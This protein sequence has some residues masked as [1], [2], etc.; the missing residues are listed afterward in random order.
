MDIE[1]LI[2]KIIPATDYQHRNGFSNT[3]IIDHLNEYEKKLLEDELIN[4]LISQTK[5][6]LVVETLAYIKSEKSLPS[7]YDLLSKN[8]DE[9]AILI[10]ATSIFEI[11]GDINMI[12]IAIDS[13]KK[14]DNFEDAYYTYKLIT[15]FYHLIKFQ[16][17]RINSVIN[18]YKNHKEYLIAHNAKQVLGKR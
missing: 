4:K 18:G 3:H 8:T 14:I 16:N 7:L 9:M 15:A 17:D 10:I 5:D 2:N 6:M 1:K 11:N 13:V 12:D